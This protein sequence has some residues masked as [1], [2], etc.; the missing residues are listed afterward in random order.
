MQRLR[1]TIVL[2]RPEA[3]PSSLVAGSLLAARFGARSGGN[4]TAATDIGTDI[5]VVYAVPEP[6]EFYLRGEEVLTPKRREEIDRICAARR[7]EMRRIFDAWCVDGGRLPGSH[8]GWREVDGGLTE[9]IAAEAAGA[10]CIVIGIP[11]APGRDGKAAVR[12]VLSQTRKPLVVVPENAPLS[13]RRHAMIAWTRPRGGLG[14]RN[15][16]RSDYASAAEMARPLLLS[17]DRVTVITAPNRCAADDPELASLTRALAEHG[18]RMQVR[19]MR[20]ARC[21]VTGAA[22]AEAYREKADIL[23]VRNYSRNQLS[24][25]MAGISMPR[26]LTSAALPVFVRD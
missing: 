25:M 23:I 9:V 11:R 26:M 6:C 12:A 18:I 17:A 2:W 19:A 13:F 4:G 15:E 24:N 8:V 10:D 20:S 1:V 7:A 16:D 3:A 5:D 14:G 22:L 21:S